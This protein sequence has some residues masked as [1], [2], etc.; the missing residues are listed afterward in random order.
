MMR[1]ARIEARG[2]ADVRAGRRDYVAAVSARRLALAALATAALL[3]VAAPAPAGAAFP[4]RDGRLV[5]SWGSFSE[6]ED[7]PYP[8]RTES[9]LQT[10]APTGGMPATLRSCVRETGKPDVGDCSTGYGTP[11]VSPDGRWLALDAGAQLA[12]MRFDGSGFRLLPAHLA[13][14]GDPA[15]S[16]NGKRLAYSAGAIAVAGQPAPPRGI[17]TSDLAGADARQVTARGTQPAWSTRSWI[18]FLRKDGIYR[19]RPDGHGLR[20]IVHRD[21]CKDVAWSPG[22]TKIAFA[23]TTKHLGGRLYVANGDGGHLRRVPIGYASPEG[24][25]WSPSGKRLAVTDFDGSLV[26]IRL[27]GS[28]ERGLVSGSAGANYNSGAGAADWQPLP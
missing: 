14:D 16:A 18:A 9:A 5:Y 1:E 19:V 12:L 7:A 20:R 6:S 11:A 8:S 24:V 4:G 10:I 26:T 13:D 28:G 15:F 17:W 2:S 21:R 27:D 22:G 25:A 3:A 23:C